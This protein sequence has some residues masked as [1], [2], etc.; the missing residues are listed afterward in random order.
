MLMIG[1]LEALAQSSPS[2]A[3]FASA[4]GYVLLI[5]ALLVRYSAPLVARRLRV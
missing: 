1:V 3:P 5:V 4:I 2:G